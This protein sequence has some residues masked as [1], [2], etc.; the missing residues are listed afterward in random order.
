M[1]RKDN[2]AYMQIGVDLSLP[3]WEG[4]VEGAEEIW[5]AVADK[6]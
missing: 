4:F 1:G 5:N 3:Y 2:Q 6:L